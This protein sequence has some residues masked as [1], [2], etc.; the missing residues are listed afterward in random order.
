LLLRQWHVLQPEIHYW[1]LEAGLLGDGCEALCMARGLR[2]SPISACTIRATHLAHCTASFLR[3]SHSG[4][5]H[6]VLCQR[7]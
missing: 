6:A 3:L 1:E 4:D 7:H 5:L 2:D